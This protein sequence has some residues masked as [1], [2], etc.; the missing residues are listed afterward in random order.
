MLSKKCNRLPS[1][2]YTLKPIMRQRKSL[3]NTAKHLQT[4]DAWS[5]CCKLKNEINQE[6]KEVH[7]SN[8][9]DNDDNNKYFWK[10]VKQL[11]KNTIGVPTLKHNNQVITELKAK[12]NVLNK[13]SILSSQIR[14]YP[15]YLSVM[16]IIY[17]AV[18]HP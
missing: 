10:Y 12:A 1:I 11:C 2:T 17:M 18:S 8:L 15:I 4:D 3:Y 13:H 7:E 6:I 9:F 14:I 16:I 5:K